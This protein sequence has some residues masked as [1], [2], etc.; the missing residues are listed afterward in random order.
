MNEYLDANRNCAVS[1][2]EYNA[3]LRSAFTGYDRNGNGTISAREVDDARKRFG[4]H[5]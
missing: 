2:T 1:R 4:E 3:E 5:E